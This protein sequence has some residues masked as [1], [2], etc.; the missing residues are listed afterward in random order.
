MEDAERLFA[1]GRANP[2]KF[3]WPLCSSAGQAPDPKRIEEAAL[4]L[5]RPISYFD[6]DGYECEIIGATAHASG[7]IVY[8]QSRAKDVGPN[9]YGANQRHID[10]SIRVHLV[11][12]AGQQR[13]AE[14]ESYNP[15]FGC[16][17]RFLDWVGPT[18]ILIYREKHWTFACRLGDIWPPRF[19]KIEDD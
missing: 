1:S 17:V 15:F 7:R 13:S 16:D 2:L 4:A 3:G 18:A 6:A 8:V 14:I 9:R 19:V 10:V 11:E 12:Q 5:G